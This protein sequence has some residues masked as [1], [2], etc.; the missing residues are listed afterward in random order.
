MRLVS[1]PAKKT[2]VVY[3]RTVYMYDHMAGQSNEFEGVGVKVRNMG[4]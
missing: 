1:V 4:I 2:P 3:V